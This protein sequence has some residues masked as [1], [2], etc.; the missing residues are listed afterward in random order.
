M[1]E[2]EEAV[3]QIGGLKA[4]GPDG[5]QGVFY[6]FFWDIIAEDV[7][8]LVMD[9]AEGKESPKKLNSAHIVLIPKVANPTSVGQ[10]SSISL[11]KYSYKIFS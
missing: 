7:N 1:E 4:P 6:K 5:F 3:F 8:G 11:C 9:F 10:Y 2:I